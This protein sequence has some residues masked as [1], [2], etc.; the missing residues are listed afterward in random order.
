VDTSARVKVPFYYFVGIVSFPA[1]L[2]FR[3]RA[4]G[5]ENVP[6]EGGVILAS[7]HL[8]A[9]DPWALGY[10]LWPA[11]RLR[12]MA[13]VELFR[14]KVLGT[15]LDWGGVF[16]VRRGESDQEALRMAIQVLHEGDVLVMF[17]EGTRRTPGQPH[18]RARTGAARIA[19]AA[20]VPVVPAALSGTDGL[21]R[22]RPWRVAYGAP[23]HTDDLV[24]LDRK[25]AA[26][27]I[28]DRLMAAIDDLARTIA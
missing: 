8:S 6:R 5:V 1:R 26:E 20:D 23:V 10:P 2:L 24:G 14:T 18:P 3:L 16:P 21:R 4:Y 17:P 11:R 19:L 7:N 13:K 12:W 28:T 27:E 9:L 25:H 15:L 22:L